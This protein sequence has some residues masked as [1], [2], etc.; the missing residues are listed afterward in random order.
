MLDLIHVEDIDVDVTL[1]LAKFCRHL[2]TLSFRNCY[3]IGGHRAPVILDNQGFPEMES[4]TVHSHCDHTFLRTLL[5]LAPSLRFLNCG[6]SAQL[7]DQLF[8]DL[9]GYPVLKSLQ[10]FHVAHC[11]LVTLTGIQILLKNCPNLRALQD[12][13]AFHGLAKFEKAALRHWV[14]VQNFDIL[15]DDEFC[16]EAFENYV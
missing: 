9:V 8:M 7:S 1:L 6:I 15:L 10:V 4:L 2:K 11:E 3:L 12:I 5:L 14:K 16:Q 13:D